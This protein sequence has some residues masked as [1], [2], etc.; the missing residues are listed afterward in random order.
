M[1][2]DPITPEELEDEAAE[3]EEGDPGAL[4]FLRAAATL[5]ALSAREDSPE[6]ERQVR[7]DL[8]TAAS[9]FH[10]WAEEYGVESQC[11]GYCEVAEA[12]IGA[13]RRELTDARAELARERKALEWAR[14]TEPPERWVATRIELECQDDAGDARAWP[15][16]DGDPGWTADVTLYKEDGEA[17]GRGE[18][19]DLAGA[20]QAAIRAAETA[21]GDDHA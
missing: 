15:T 19:S 21:K 3:F 8:L 4:P 12:Y 13:L 6:D 16:G 14:Y 7:D 5:R 11:A 2:S 9:Q 20:I 10:E 17:A 1:P 18:G